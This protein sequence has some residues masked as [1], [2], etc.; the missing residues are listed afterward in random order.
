MLDKRVAGSDKR[1]AEKR[2]TDESAQH[3]NE[4][5]TSPGLDNVRYSAENKREYSRREER[6]KN[7]P[8]DPQRGL[9]VPKLDVP[10]GEGGK[11]PAKIPELSEIEACEA[12]R[13]TNTK[14]VVESHLRTRRLV[15]APFRA[16]PAFKLFKPRSSANHSIPGTYSGSSPGA[17][18]RHRCTPGR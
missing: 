15:V 4:N 13:R 8:G 17:P 2:P 14:M 5:R 1:G 10:D 18:E 12:S 6:L 9:P 11:E 16:V 7:D 3:K